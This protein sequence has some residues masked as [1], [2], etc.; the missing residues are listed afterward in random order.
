MMKI[1]EVYCKNKK[2]TDKSCTLHMK[3]APWNTE[4]IA[5]DCFI[6]DKNGGCKNWIEKKEN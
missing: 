4:I 3:N 6:T 2:C 1:G 5:R